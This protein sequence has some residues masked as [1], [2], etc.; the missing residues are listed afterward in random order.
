MSK[1]R[2]KG[3]MNQTEYDENPQT[4]HIFFAKSKRNLKTQQ[5]LWSTRWK[6]AQTVLKTNPKVPVRVFTLH[7]DCRL[8]L[9]VC[10][11]RGPCWHCSAWLAVFQPLVQIELVALTIWESEPLRL[12]RIPQTHL[13]PVSFVFASV[14]P[15]L[16][17]KC[18]IT[19]RHTEKQIHGAFQSATFPTRYL[20]SIF[21]APNE[22]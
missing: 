1:D 2:K 17:H 10:G 7:A 15:R 13:V 22:N 8:L 3:T 20:K 5:K 14:L 9:R 6:K 18:K 11:H 16:C 4:I 19:Q 12:F 21:K